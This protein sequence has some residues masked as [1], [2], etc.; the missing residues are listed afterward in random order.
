MACNQE[1]PTRYS[2][3]RGGSGI[4]G[5]HGR[6]PDS[7]TQPALWVAANMQGKRRCPAIVA[8]STGIGQS[9]EAEDGDDGIVN[10]VGH[11][12]ELPHR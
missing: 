4:A 7:A 8:V 2:R 10:L 3:W 9:H 5:D 6:K 12:G 1:V 11:A